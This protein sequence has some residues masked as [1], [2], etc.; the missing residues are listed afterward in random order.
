[1]SIRQPFNFQK[2]IED[3]KELF[4][5]PVGNKCLYTES[6]DFIIM[7]VGGPNARKDYHYNETEEFFY[8][9]KG[10]IIV[11]IQEDGKV[12]EIPVK[13]GEVFLL[14]AKVPHSP[15]RSEDSIGLVIECQRSANER[16]G[17]QWYCDKCN[18]P[19]HD[20]YFKLESIEKDFIPRFKEFYSSEEMRT[21]KNCKHVMETDKRFS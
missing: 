5:P 1:M 19:L 13:E 17:L 14:P 9:I 2:W 7:V 6:E 12:K 8:Q 3:N 4:K 11:K 18:K 10:D 20:T 21:C 16:D 15:I